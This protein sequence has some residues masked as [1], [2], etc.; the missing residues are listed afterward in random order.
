MTLP[1]HSA[2]FT[3]VELMVTIAILSVVIGFGVPSFNTL[4][5]NYRITTTSTDTAGLLQ[6][7][8]AEAV[9]L[10]GGVRVSALDNDINKGLRV[11]VDGN[12]NN[13]FDSG[14]ELR[15][16]SSIP[17]SLAADIGGNE[18]S[19]LQLVFNA[20]GETDLASKLTLALCDDRSGAYGRVLEV[21]VSGAMRVL[22]NTAC[23]N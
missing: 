12:S 1:R 3:L 11:W 22:V 5:K 21:L 4:V 7:A 20:Q 13:S 18:A 2:G 6:F 16:V 19:Q 9:R 17:L 23:S 15:V 10:G 8:R 14:E